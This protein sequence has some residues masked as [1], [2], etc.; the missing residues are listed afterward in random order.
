[1]IKYS[2][3]LTVLL[4]FS[5]L[6]L[7]A[8]KKPTT[9]TPVKTEQKTTN[10]A[11]VTEPTLFTGNFSRKITSM[12]EI[13]CDELTDL[14]VIIP[15]TAE[16]K[17]YDQVNVIAYA[18]NGT[19]FTEFKGLYASMNTDSKEYQQEFANKKELRFVLFNKS[20]PTAESEFYYLNPKRQTSK[21]NH[22]FNEL[23]SKEFMDLKIIAYGG[24]KTTEHWNSEYGVF[25]NDYNFKLI[26]ASIAMHCK[27]SLADN[28]YQAGT[29]NKTFI[30]DFGNLGKLSQKPNPNLNGANFKFENGQELL[31]VVRRKGFDYPY[32]DYVKNKITRM[33]TANFN[34]LTYKLSVDEQTE[35]SFIYNYKEQKILGKSKKVFKTGFYYIF[36]INPD[37]YLEVSN[38]ES[39]DNV[40]VEDLKKQQ[41]LAKD[42]K[43]KMQ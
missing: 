17:K 38:T 9:K 6:A 41:A 30:L 16:M 3:L 40:T 29:D 43:A 11:V 26:S 14:E 20:N 18:R 24:Y 32:S 7:E 27:S 12:D 15:F 25:V 4:S 31:V 8:Q 35:N 37:F 28:Q 34:G 13:K 2:V 39:Q 21:A 10:A 1:M 5:L 23:L 22:S 42:F 36:P 33:T 19:E